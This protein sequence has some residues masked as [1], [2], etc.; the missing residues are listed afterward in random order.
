MEKTITE[1][2]RTIIGGA[3]ATAVVIILYLIFAV[4]F[5]SLNFNDWVSD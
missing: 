5:G 3:V 2:A 4:V 1:T